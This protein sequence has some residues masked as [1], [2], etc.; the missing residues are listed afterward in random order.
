MCILTLN[1]VQNIINKQAT[2]DITFTNM[3]V[4]ELV[5]ILTLLFDM[6]FETTRKKKDYYIISHLEQQENDN[7][8]QTSETMI[9]RKTTVNMKKDSLFLEMA[10]FPFLFPRGHGVYNGKSHFNEY[11]KYRMNALFSP[12]TLYKPYL[13]YM[14]D[15]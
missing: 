7:I 11:L 12:F 9:V 5:Y 8:P 6:C 4:L 10:L 13:L 15:L 3:D 1:V 2:H 14:Y